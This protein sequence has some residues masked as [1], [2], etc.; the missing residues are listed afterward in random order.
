LTI[1][2]Q[3][4]DNLNVAQLDHRVCPNWENGGLMTRSVFLPAGLLMLIAALVISGCGS[5]R[6]L[7]SVS[8]NPATADA[9]SFANGMVPFAANGVFSK[10]PSPAPLTSKDI[11]WCV[12][13]SSGACAGNI[14]LGAI[15][16]GNGV[17]QCNTGFVG[18]ATILAGNIASA[19]MNPDGGSQLKVFGTAQLTCP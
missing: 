17:A 12:G 5:N 14:N 15:V 2:P 7:K 16:D 8:L 13:N 4:K 3:W 19:S 1:G 18:T 6:Q 9:K 10:P 11:V